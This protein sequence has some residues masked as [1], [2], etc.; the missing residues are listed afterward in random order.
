MKALHY[1]ACVS[2]FLAG[3]AHGEDT[4]VLVGDRIDV[5]LTFEEA[6]GVYKEET[7]IVALSYFERRE[8]F[9]AVTEVYAY[10]NNDWQII[11]TLPRAETLKLACATEDCFLLL[12][13]NTGRMDVFAVNAESVTQLPAKGTSGYAGYASLAVHE[14]TPFV[15]FRDANVQNLTSVRKYMDGEWQSV[16][17]AGA[18][19]DKNVQRTA[20][21]VN[22]QG[23]PYIAYDVI[24]DIGDLTFSQTFVKRFMEDT[25]IPLGN[26]TKEQIITNKHVS[27]TFDADGF[28]YVALCN[29]L[30]LEMK[31][32]QTEEQWMPIDTNE[33]SCSASDLFY[34]GANN[35]SQPA[36][37][38]IQ[39]ENGEGRFSVVVWD[40][41]KWETLGPTLATEFRLKGFSMTT[42]NIPY[43]LFYEVSLIQRQVYGVRTIGEAP[44]TPPSPPP[45]SEA[46]ASQY[47]LVTF[48]FA[49]SCVMV[50]L[51]Q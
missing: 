51:L 30:N 23:V 13:N 7:P 18:V 8:T 1:L 5:G 12:A 26:V 22:Q 17:E 47:G 10:K 19:V 27:M 46:Y 21:A 39:R 48:F 2:L 37:A 34:L 36:I 6:L 14:N 44:P 25:W 29:F 28:P 31:K 20:L 3:W 11:A 42:S 24:R 45:D 43:A 40:G 50:Q 33:M 15:A 16:G 49:L 38:S 35:Q 32:Y 41:T 9:R 4:W